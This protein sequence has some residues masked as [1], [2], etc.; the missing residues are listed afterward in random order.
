MSDDYK[1]GF[2]DGFDAG[3][4]EGKKLS[5][6]KIDWPKLPVYPD[7]HMNARCTVCGMDFSKG[8]W[9]YVCSHSRCPSRVTCG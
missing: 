3:L 5:A 7:P 2:R 9:G 8:V 6:P 4:E 1:R